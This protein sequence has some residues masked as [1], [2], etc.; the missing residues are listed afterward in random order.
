MPMFSENIISVNEPLRKLIYR[1]VLAQPPTH[2]LQP[3]VADIF[4]EAA[5]THFWQY[6]A[7]TLAEAVTSVAMLTPGRLTQTTYKLWA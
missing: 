4:H 7:V 6:I 1:A 5:T 3:A 2:P